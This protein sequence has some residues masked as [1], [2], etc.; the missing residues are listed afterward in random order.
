VSDSVAPTADAVRLR[1]AVEALLFR[2][3]ALLDAREFSA[4]LELFADECLYW[5]PSNT[6]E[7]D[8]SRHVSIVY[9]EH[10]QLKERV[11]RL[12]S[13]LAYAQ[14]PQSRSAHLVGN[15][16]ILAADGEAID[17]ESV[18]VVTEFRRD[19]Q[20][21]HAGRYHH[22]LRRQGEDLRIVMKKVA[23]IN[24]DGHLGNLSL[25]L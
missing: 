21:V 12:Q 3:A 24:N 19:K 9:D 6:D 25:L 10:P 15:V 8:P 11:W 13:G 14:E 22:R 20:F 1:A 4:W 17:A 2:E 7:L 5:I 23:L 18:F 16:E